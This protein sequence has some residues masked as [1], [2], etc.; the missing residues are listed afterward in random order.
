[1]NKTTRNGQAFSVDAILAVIVLAVFLSAMYFLSAEANQDSYTPEVLKKGA[2]DALRMLDKSGDLGSVNPALI[3]STLNASFY[4]QASWKFDASYYNYSGGF[5]SAV[6]I[7]L[8]IDDSGAKKTVSAQREFVV[9]ENGAVK[10]YGV[11]RLRVW[12]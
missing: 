10:Y 9:M 12:R 11:A 7:S 4:Q 3:N 8:G 2:D 1:M 6:N 5:V